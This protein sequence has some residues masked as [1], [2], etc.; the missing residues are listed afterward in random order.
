[1]TSTDPLPIPSQLEAQLSKCKTVRS[2]ESYVKS[3]TKTAEVSDALYSTFLFGMQCS[4]VVV[5]WFTVIGLFPL[6]LNLHRKWKNPEPS[7]LL[8]LFLPSKIGFSMTRDNYRSLNNPIAAF[9]WI[10]DCNYAVLSFD[11]ASFRCHVS[12]NPLQVLHCN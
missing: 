4:I 5:S 2:S 8:C 3:R 1:M 6:S 12:S 7:F 11:C 10:I 9:L